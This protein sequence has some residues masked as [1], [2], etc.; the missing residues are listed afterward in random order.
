[1][2]RVLSSS[3]RWHCA[4]G[5]PDVGQTAHVDPPAERGD[6]QAS[7]GA[8]RRPQIKRSVQFALTPLLYGSPR[9]SRPQRSW[10]FRFNLTT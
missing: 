8:A 7:D 5:R 2:S 1:M 4:D 6:A 3:G 9:E 10:K